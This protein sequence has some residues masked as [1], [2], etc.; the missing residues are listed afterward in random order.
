ML[1][2]TCKQCSKDF[3]TYPSRV[4][5][6]K[7]KYCSKECFRIGR[8]G[9]KPWNTGKICPQLSESKK[10]DKNPRWK[11]GISKSESDKKYS[12]TKSGKEAKR[13]ARKKWIKANPEKNAAS[14]KEYHNRMMSTSKQYRIKRAISNQIWCRLKRQ[15]KGEKNGSICNYLPYSIEELVTH[16]ESKFV[17]GMSWENYGEWHIDHIIPDSSFDYLSMSDSEFQKSWSLQNLQPL[18]AKDNL[19]KGNTC[20][21]NRKMV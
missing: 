3:Q 18:W 1:N 8:K 9:K 4:A 21:L 12:Q 16:L 14:K 19:S 17:D 7:G 15:R 5:V 11:G 6:G 10:G 2:V 13:K 20:I